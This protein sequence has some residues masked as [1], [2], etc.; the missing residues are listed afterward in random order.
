MARELHDILAHSV[1]LMGVQADAAEE[2]LAHEPERARPVLQSIQQT[3]RDSVVELRR[4]LG[5]LREAEA[6]ELDSPQPDIRQLDALVGRMR[7]AGLPVDLVVEGNARPLPPG[8]ELA[9][10]R[11]IQEGLTNALKHARPARVEVHLRYRPTALDV[12]VTNDGVE[13]GAD[14]NG[15]GHGLV[16]MN[17][18]LTLYGGALV[19]GERPGGVF[20]IDA[21][22]PLEP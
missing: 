15:D 13:A 18:R 7:N 21:H 5:I 3:A 22:I 10:F 14:G 9:A 19:A 4:L 16:G 11:V 2:V 17:E 8:I 12:N 1:S 6:Q 20:S